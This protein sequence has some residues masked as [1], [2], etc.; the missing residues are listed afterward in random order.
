MDGKNK[1]DI[2]AS[3]L[4]VLVIFDHLFGAYQ[5]LSTG[6]S[7]NNDLVGVDLMTLFGTSKCRSDSRWR[8]QPLIYTFGSCTAISQ[9]ILTYKTSLD[10][11]SYFTF[12]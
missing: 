12:I 5:S 10:L 3:K 7:T 4:E 9:P 2:D 11:Q 1:L 8:H 6:N